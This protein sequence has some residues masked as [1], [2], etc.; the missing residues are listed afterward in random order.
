MP[1]GRPDT[2]MISSPIRSAEAAGESGTTSPTTTRVGIASCVMAA[3]SAF[4]SEVANCWVFS[5]RTWSSVLPG[6]KICARGTTCRSPDAQA[7]SIC[8][9]VRR[10]E[11]A[12]V[13]MLRCPDVGKVGSPS[14]VTTGAPPTSPSVS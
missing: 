3:S 11:T 10:S 7:R 12:T 13:V 1:T 5:A 9:K 8:T 2:A 4:D 6:G 14:T